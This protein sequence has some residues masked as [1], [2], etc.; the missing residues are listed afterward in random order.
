MEKHVRDKPPGMSRSDVATVRSLNF[1]P[2]SNKET[3]ALSKEVT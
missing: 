3:M 2:K 1:I